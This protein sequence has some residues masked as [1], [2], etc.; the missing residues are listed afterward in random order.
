[1]KAHDSRRTKLDFTERP[2]CSV[3]RFG[4]L[5]GV[6]LRDQESFQREGLV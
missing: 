3:P 6:L 4:G 5:R 1:M 2:D